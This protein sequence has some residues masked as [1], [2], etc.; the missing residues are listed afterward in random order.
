MSNKEE[1]VQRSKLAEQA[2]RYDDMANAMKKVTEANSELT[3]EERNLLSVAYKN[4]V[5]ARRS[6]WRVI[7]SIE[8]KTEG[9]ERKQQMAKEYRE[10][11]EKELKDICQE[12]LTLLDKFL[13]PKATTP[14]SKV[15]YLKMKGDYY[16]YLSEVAT[17]DERQ[18]V[19]EESQRAYNDAFDI[20]KNQMQP[21]HPIR[22]GLAL[23]FSVFYYEILNAPDRACHLA[24]QAFDDAIAELDTL[25]EESYKDSTLIMQLLRDNL[26]LWTSD[27]PDPDETNPPEEHQ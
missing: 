20:A 5:G 13:V 1:E 21:T 9:S 26:T 25:N 16:R 8:Q 14:E 3:N 10:K 15:F 23:N 19:I 17:G 18:K 22:L 27:A 24:K 11:I 7:S 12:V 2:E 4:V 6:S